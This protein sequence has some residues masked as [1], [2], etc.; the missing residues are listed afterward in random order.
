M[1]ISEK[2]SEKHLE[3]G[4]G[5][6]SAIVIIVS[7]SKKIAK[8]CSNGFRLRRA[9]KVVEKYWKAGP[10]SIYLSFARVGHDCLGKYWDKALQCVICISTHK[11]ENYYCSV[12]SCTVKMGKICTNV[13]LKYANCRA[14]YQAIAFRYSD[15][16]KVQ[17]E[18]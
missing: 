18:L 10:N 14:Q 17:V 11:V 4:I 2:W 3:A 5:R 8:L 6:R 16:L 13:I 7:T 9:L 15:R 12:T 1:L